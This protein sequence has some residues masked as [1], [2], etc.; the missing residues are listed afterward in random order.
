MKKLFAVFGLCV[1]L[2]PAC[3]NSNGGMSAE[4]VVSRIE[5][6]MVGAHRK[7]GNV[8][9]DRYRHPQETLM[10]FG[11]KPDMTVV[12][13]WPGGGWYAEILAPVLRGSGKYYAAGYD[14]DNPDQPAYRARTQRAFEDKLAAHPEIYDEVIV[15]KL[16]LPDYREIAPAGSADLVLTFRNTHSFMRAGQ[17]ADMFDA[18]YAALKP[19]GS[20]GVVQ[21]RAR[22][23]TSLEDMKRTGY[24]TEEQVILLAK[25]AGFV[26]TGRSEVNANPL[27]TAD[28]PEGVWTLPPSLRMGETDRDRYMA[29]GESDRMTL[30]FI[31]PGPGGVPNVPE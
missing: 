16:S 7:P 22:P 27:D 23:G 6:A 30:R 10:F 5:S 14:A 29:I 24:V 2:L 20:L 21:H 3:A 15:S 1:V 28:H 11:L 18:F 8:T 9:R 19:G 31:K 17:A 25:D 26:L 13:I 12:E 4:P